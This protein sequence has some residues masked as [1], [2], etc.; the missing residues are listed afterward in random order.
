M[1]QFARTG[2]EANYTLDQID[3]AIQSAGD[4]MVRRT[5][6]LIQLDTYTLAAGVAAI[7]TLPTDFRPGR[8]SEAYLEGGAPIV[9]ITDST[10]SG[11]AAI[12]TVADGV[13]SSVG[14]IQGGTGYTSP[15][16]TL[17]GGAGT[18]A[19]ATATVS[20]GIITAINVTA[21]GSGYTATLVLDVG[22]RTPHF[23][24]TEGQWVG[25][26]TVVGQRRISL[27]VIPFNE[28]LTR[29]TRI[30][31]TMQPT[32]L[33]F[34][35][36]QT[37]Q[38]YPTPDQAYTMKIRWNPMFTEWTPGATDATTVATTVNV[39]LDLMR[40]TLVFG[41]TSILQMSNTEQHYATTAAARFEKFILDTLRA[42]STGVKQVYSFARRR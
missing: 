28:F 37:A 22:Y 19:T 8:M 18:G 31:M 38:V 2:G 35:T 25:E 30:P 13:V 23:A 9:T 4:E 40:P 42:G 41:A 15:T 6:C 17:S 33:S 5:S 3:R 7:S 36:W 20:G 24:Y 16:V 34:E 26:G 14:V 32:T 21:G 11:A 12:A 29:Q 10:G 39:P 1:Q 27:E